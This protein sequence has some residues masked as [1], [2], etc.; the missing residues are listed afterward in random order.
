MQQQSLAD[1]LLNS[2]HEE[3]TTQQIKNI[4]QKSKNQNKQNLRQGSMGVTTPTYTPL[5]IAILFE[6]GEPKMFQVSFNINKAE[7]TGK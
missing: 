3:K 5:M 1:Q 4:I 7:V 2:F 6:N